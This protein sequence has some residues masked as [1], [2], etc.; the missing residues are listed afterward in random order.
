[1]SLLAGL[2]SIFG[3]IFGTLIMLFPI[4]ELFVY[5]ANKDADFWKFLVLLGVFASRIISPISVHALEKH[6]LHQE[7]NRK[8]IL[9][10][11]PWSIFGGLQFGM[12]GIVL[13]PLISVFPFLILEL[14]EMFEEWTE[15]KTVTDKA[16]VLKKYRG[17]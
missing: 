7:D 5:S 6:L 4:I 15:S 1:M 3:D 16:R 13:G 11:V 10:I 8:T 2:L 12:G 14:K 17:L 9:T